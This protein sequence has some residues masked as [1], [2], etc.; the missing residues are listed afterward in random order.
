[1][2]FVDVIEAFVD[3]RLKLIV[4]YAKWGDLAKTRS[5]LALVA[6][7]VPRADDVRADI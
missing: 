4:G 7:H 3:K 5:F 2:L 6:S 1:M